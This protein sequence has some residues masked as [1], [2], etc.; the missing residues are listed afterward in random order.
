[1]VLEEAFVYFPAKYPEG[2][3][4]YARRSPYPVEERTLT[5]SDGTALNACLLHGSGARATI[6]F[7]HGNAG[8]LTYCFDWALELAALPASVLLLDYRGYGKSE[9]K[10]SEEGIYRDS[11]A[12]YRHLVE[13]ERVSPDR[14]VVYGIS[15]GGA[16]ACYL[17]SRLPC[18]S[19]VLHST[20]TDG[21]DMAALKV[22]FLPVRWFA[23]KTFD[24]LGRIRAI[25]VPKLIV[26]SRDDEMI[27]Y[28]MAV[29]LA[30]AARAPKTLVTL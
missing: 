4:G 28:E 1:V 25:S 18:A 15:L 10:P 14:L 29:R 9:G 22:P 23:R 13:K 12:A 2:D 19:V 6:L 26:H 3:W 24:N 20:F 17:A 8:N 27:P 21:L 16:P 11:E 5:A 7:L 30:D